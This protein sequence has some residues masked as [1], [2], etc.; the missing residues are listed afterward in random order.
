VEVLF[1]SSSA[2]DHVFDVGG[3]KRVDLLAEFLD[4]QFGGYPASM[5]SFCAHHALVIESFGQRGRRVSAIRFG[6]LGE[7]QCGGRLTL[8]RGAF[9]RSNRTLAFWR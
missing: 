8:R 1:G 7:Q 4:D 5:V 2:F 6:Q 9:H 3:Q